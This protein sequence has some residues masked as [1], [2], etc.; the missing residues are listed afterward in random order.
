[1]IMVEASQQFTDFKWNTRNDISSLSDCGQHGGSFGN[2]Y[3]AAFSRFP[4]KKLAVIVLTNLNPTNVHWIC[5]NIA[6]FYFPE[7]KNIDQLKLELDADTSLNK[8]VRAFLEGLG[9]GNL[10]TTQV[11]LNF[12][13]RINPVTKLL[14]DGQ[15]SKPLF[16]VHSDR[17][18]NN[19]LLRYGVPVE[20]INYYKTIVENETHYLA[21]YFTAN[22]KVAD[23]RGY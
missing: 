17:I 19:S 23:M 3:T 10:D 9:N 12:K 22:N 21:I 2:G 5:Y 20:K 15:S 8:R 4:E 7:L 18:K 1:M 16:F 11:T 13:Q 14:F 6:G